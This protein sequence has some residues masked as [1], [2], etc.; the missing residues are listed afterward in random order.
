MRVAASVA[1]VLAWVA[2]ALIVGATAAAALEPYPPGGAPPLEVTGDV[3]GLEAGTVGRL[4][5]RV[6]N[7]GEVPQ[8][9]RRVDVDVA[10]ST[11]PECTGA[12]RVEDWT[13]SA[14]VPAGGSLVRSVEVRV[15]PPA[16]Q[17][18]RGVA[19]ELRFTAG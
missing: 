4:A 9:L 2:C 16:G 17:A 6:S 10:S 3:T 14:S 5:L 15:V 11:V 13:G 19:W 12:L 1:R 8:P 7:R 18:C